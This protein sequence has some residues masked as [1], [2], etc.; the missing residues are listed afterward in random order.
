MANSTDAFCTGKTVIQGGRSFA[1]GAENLYLFVAERG[2]CWIRESVMLALRDGWDHV[3]D[4][5]GIGVG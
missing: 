1:I 2:R 4:W 5:A 3:H